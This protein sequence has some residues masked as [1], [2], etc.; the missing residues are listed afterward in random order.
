MYTLRMHSTMLPTKLS[1]PPPRQ[2]RVAR[3]RLTDA[4]T[5]GIHRKLTLVSAP[6]GF[7]KSTLVAEWLAS[8]RGPAAWVSLDEGDGDLVSFLTY[9]IAAIRTITGRGDELLEAA[10]SPGASPE[11]ILAGLIG[12]LAPV[13]DDFV[14]VLD[15][16]HLI[17]SEAV[18]RALAYLV[19]HQPRAMHLVIA[20]R[21]DPQLGL[22]RL[23]ARNELTEI[24]ASDLRF[25]RDESRAF[26]T[27]V[28]G[29]ELA[30]EAVATLDERTEGW[31]AGLQ[32]AALSMRNAADRESFVAAFS[33]S[34]R[35]VLDY[36]AEDVL[37][38][39]PA[40]ARRFL[41][42]TSV[43]DRFSADL[44]DAVTG[45]TDSAAVIDHLDRTN[46]FVIP[47]DSTRE[48]YRYHRLLLDLLRSRLDASAE[49]TAALHARASD[50]YRRADLPLEAFGHAVA[51]GDIDR[52]ADILDGDGLPL[53]YRGVF[54]PVERWLVSLPPEELDRRPDLRI[55]CA[56]VLTTR[57]A[58]TG[59]VSV[60]LDRAEES[61]LGMPTGSHRD[62][63]R[64]QIAAIRA[65][66]AIPQGALEPV[67]TNGQIAL[68]LLNSRNAP[69]RTTVAWSLGYARQQLGE[70]AGAR[71]AFERAIAEG[72][73]SGNRVITIG[74]TISLGQTLERER[75]LREA[76]RIYLDVLRLAGDPPLPYACE[77]Y[78]GLARIR[79][80]QN[81]LAA[82]RTRAALA[83]ELG[84]HLEN[85]DTPGMAR[86]LE[87]R[88]DLAEGR[89]DAATAALEQARRLLHDRG[90]EHHDADLADIRV[91]LQ[92]RAGHLAAAM[93]TARSHNLTDRIAQL[94]LLGGDADRAL[95]T[96]GAYVETDDR[97]QIVANLTSHAI[98]AAAL[99]TSDE[100][101]RA[102]ALLDAI[103]PVAESESIIRTFVDLGQLL[104]GVLD[105]PE[106][107]ARHPEW[108]ARLL[109]A[110]DDSSGPGALADPLSRREIEVLRLIAA[111]LSNREIGD[112]LFIALD[113]VKGHTRRIYEKL[114][115]RRR[116]EA[117]SKATEIGLLERPAASSP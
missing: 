95:A 48:W 81:D 60:L 104:R 63:L 89:A 99:W 18:D 26:L 111:G 10:R 12:D 103:A 33:G 97:A 57:G 19:E 52:A 28:M 112:R 41:D 14:V 13:A 116:T 65:L 67:I 37:D 101:T 85:V 54:A 3:S 79:Y 70:L 55:A 96:L 29:L 74:A 61:V 73:A 31:V 8:R 11:Q 36:L 5:A 17:D 110:L 38:R 51:A 24:R 94:E 76:E 21:E 117:V 35:Y 114:D 27:Q 20:T 43:L 9:L 113:T 44:C 62:D 40:D 90:I 56:W 34:N 1:V 50:W 84:M 107:R 115:V 102:R 109:G 2:N 64:G 45:R 59:D 68:E 4:L 88:I 32:L 105:D 80:E 30:P 91:L 22:S 93:E 77:A 6:A 25:D 83:G 82:A 46:L 58:P 66:Q 7:G 92:M 49:T 42:Q 71:A 53:H 106:L 72:Q 47:L 87:A 108:T 75:R 16:Y 100:R 98:A 23:R 78:L 39:L 15:D 69:V 86:V